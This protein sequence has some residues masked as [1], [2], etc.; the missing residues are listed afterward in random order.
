MVSQ[1]QD[2][3]GQVSSTAGECAAI[4]AEVVNVFMVPVAIQMAYVAA[5]L[6]EQLSGHHIAVGDALL[7]GIVLQ[8]EGAV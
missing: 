2:R 6:V 1:L 7:P 8:F 3:H 5:A 4:V